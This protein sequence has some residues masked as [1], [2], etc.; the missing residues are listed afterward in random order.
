MPDNLG[1]QPMTRFQA[2][3]YYVVEF[4]IINNGFFSNSFNI[5]RGVRQGYPLSSSLFIICI[6][7]LS[8][9]IQS[10][11]HINGVSLEPDEEIKQSLFADDAT[12]FYMTVL[13]HSI[14]YRIAYPFWNGIGS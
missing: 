4:I 14:I 10:N 12:Y 1:N 5:E 3:E 9:Y 7:Y 6:E 11:K 8:H 2:A 13:T